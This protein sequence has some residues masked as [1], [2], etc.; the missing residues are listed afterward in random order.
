M[1]VEEHFLK[2]VAVLVLRNPRKLMAQLA[3]ESDWTLARKLEAQ[4][5]QVQLLQ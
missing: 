1:Q 5:V 4:L 3:R 2:L